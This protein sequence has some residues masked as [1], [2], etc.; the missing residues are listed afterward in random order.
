[1]EELQPTPDKAQPW[2]ELHDRAQRL[3]IWKEMVDATLRQATDITK[4][5]FILSGNDPE[6]DGVKSDG[7]K[8]DGVN[9]DG[10]NNDG[11]NND[12]SDEAHI[13]P[14]ESG[15]MALWLDHESYIESSTNALMEMNQNMLLFGTYR[16][17]LS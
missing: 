11:V 6:N 13:D 10:V 1:M 4:C 17:M 15:W 7:V 5:F 3:E 14:H 16:P 2:A 12:G 9:N 8:S